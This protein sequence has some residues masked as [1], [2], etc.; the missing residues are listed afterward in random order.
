[1]F[2]DS[3]DDS[4]VALAKSVCKPCPVR[5]AC[6]DY[7][8]AHRERYGIWGGLEVR[9]RWAVAE[10]R[11]GRT[12]LRRCVA[13]GQEKPATEFRL[14]RAGPRTRCVPCHDEYM[15]PVTAARN[16]RRRAQREQ[17]SA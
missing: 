17:E 9:E 5:A 11:Q 16:A 14:N 7:A 3:D 4:A 13:C 2:P 15:R 8:V 1:M 12:G 6:L 10:L